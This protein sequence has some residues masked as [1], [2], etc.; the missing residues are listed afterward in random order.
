MDREAFW[1]TKTLAR[2]AAASIKRRVADI[3]EARHGLDTDRC[4]KAG[5]SLLHVLQQLDV[6]EHDQIVYESALYQRDGCPFKVNSFSHTIMTAAQTPRVAGRSSYQLTV[7][8]VKLGKLWRPGPV[9]T[10]QYVVDY[11]GLTMAKTDE[12]LVQAQYL[13]VTRLGSY[14]LLG[15]KQASET[16]I[17]PVLPLQRAAIELV[18]ENL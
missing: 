9:N 5:R 8:T 2:S 15:L 13:D 11:T 6:P 16:P 14:A 4:I 10:E 18:Q 12:V 3:Y 7:N 1:V 17:A